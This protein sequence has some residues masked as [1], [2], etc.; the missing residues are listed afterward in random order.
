MRSSKGFTLDPLSKRNS[1]SM[2]QPDHGF[3][4]AMNLGKANSYGMAPA[5]QQF[6]QE[7]VILPKQNTIVCLDELF[8]RGK[9]SL[10]RISETMYGRN[11]RF[12]RREP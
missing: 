3:S 1:S 11:G 4:P 10:K 5:S 7:K 2:Q 8:G 6:S 9:Q 12:K